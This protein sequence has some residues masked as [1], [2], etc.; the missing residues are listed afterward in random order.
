[1]FAF[2]L[3]LVSVI[4]FLVLWGTSLGAVSDWLHI[5]QGTGFQAAEG[6]VA[7]IG[8]VIAAG[9]MWV[10]H[11]RSLLR[12]LRTGGRSMLAAVMFYLLSV[13][14]LLG[15]SLMISGST[16]FEEVAALLTGLVESSTLQLG[17]QAL[18][19]LIGASLWAH[20]VYV[21]YQEVKYDMA[22]DKKEA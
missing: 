15:V 22:L 7:N 17:A 11:W 19:L 20:H 2:Y 5:Q 9:L 3:F 12:G 10:F 1:M 16:F 8:W 18:K 21:F 13:V 4:S 14:S 6:L